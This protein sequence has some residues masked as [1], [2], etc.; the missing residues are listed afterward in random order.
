MTVS[1]IARK[2]KALG[3]GVT[4]SFPFEF[5]IFT[6]SDITVSKIDVTTNIHTPQILGIDYDVKLNDRGDNGGTI[7]YKAAPTTNQYSFIIRELALT[8]ETDFPKEGKFP[9]EDIEDTLDKNTMLIQQVDDAL[10]LAIQVPSD[11]INFDPNL[12][13]PVTGKALLWNETANGLENSVDNINDITAKVDAITD[14]GSGIII[15]D[16]ERIAIVEN[17]GHRNTLTGNPHDVTKADLS[18][19]NVDNTSDAN[20][21]I[22]TEAATALSGKLSNSATP[23]DVD[24]SLNRRYVTDAQLVVVGN[25][26][27]ANTGDQT[28]PTKTSDLTNDSLVASIGAGTNISV[29]NTDPRNPIV[30]ATGTATG[31]AN[32]ASNVGAGTGLF[33]EKDAVDLRFKSLVEGT[34]VTFTV[35][36]DSITINAAGGA[37]AV[38]SVFGRIGQV[39]AESGDYTKAQVGLGNVDNTSDANKPI[40]TL[41]QTALDLKVDENAAITAST[42]TKITY[43]AKGLVT[44]GTDATTA[45]IGVSTDKNY[46][47]DAEKT[48]IGN[49]SNTNT[50]DQTITLT[51]NVTGSGTGSFATTIAD[52]VI[53]NAKMADDAIGIAELS[54]TGTPSSTTYYCGNNTWSS[55][56][57]APSDEVIVTGSRSLAL[58][59]ANKYIRCTNA[60]AAV[61]TIEPNSTTPFPLNTEIAFDSQG[62]GSVTFAL[63]AGVTVNSF[64]SKLEMNLG[65][66]A[67]L[68]K[69][70]INA[71]KLVGS[72]K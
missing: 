2:E 43:D 58:T 68:R 27:G 61:L 36:V 23:A 24:A 20:K 64:E 15:S 39:V 29:D 38:D 1:D 18:I 7:T 5:K 55:V 10:G 4:K 62:A 25:T 63:G 51:G 21:P 28:L 49:T 13:S 48:V 26:S 50:G 41:Q 42:K 45:D 30:N 69:Y 59:D 17:I 34:N 70:G 60:A 52:N 32:T 54:A 44:G 3:N 33:K 35:G 47:T 46:V 12:P 14:T 72:L 11:V 22:S 40:S 19:E 67:A 31:E 9:E 53:T 56:T 8:Q 37:G 57:A 6:T 71:W 16:S 65:S 66:G